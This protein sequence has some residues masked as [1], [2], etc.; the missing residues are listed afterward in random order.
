[1][2]YLKQLFAKNDT[3]DIDIFCQKYKHYGSANRDKVLY[4]IEEN[5]INLG[6][7]AMYR[8][9]LEYLYFADICGYTP[10]ICADDHFT[11]KEDRPLY[12][13]ANSFEYYFVQPSAI[14][15]EEAKRSNR[16]ILSDAV[17]RKMV[18][19]VLTGK[20]S[21]YKYNSRYLHMMGH[22]AGKY[23][24]FNHMTK[25]YIEDSLKKLDFGKGKIL[26]IHVRGTDYRAKFNNHPV[27][28]TEEDCFAA[29]DGL[30]RKGAYDR[31]FLATDDIRILE[32]FI[33][34]YGKQL[35]FYEDVERSNK[36]KSVAFS[37][38]SRE[39]HKYLLGLE[40]IRDMYTLSL[41]SGLI[42]GISQ[43]AICAQINKVSRGERYEYVR[44]IDK[45]IYRNGRCFSRK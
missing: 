9:W 17:H 35:L 4:Y 31:L 30:V 24:T 18:E 45:G 22:I 27:Y 13:T 12:G 33:K 11:Y 21:H 32:S 41:C 43:V 38:N 20:T 23:M 19:L 29:I 7:F 40:V 39:H 44:I 3:K 16:V 10:V 6:F 26:G 42:A 2:D 36:N 34:K 25:E 1:M 5:S 37:S 28:V 14:S 8:Y 15:P